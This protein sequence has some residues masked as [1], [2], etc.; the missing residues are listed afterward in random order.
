MNLYLSKE[1]RN[2]KSDNFPQNVQFINR[3][4]GFIYTVIMSILLLLLSLLL[5]LNACLFKKTTINA[6]RQICLNVL[7]FANLQSLAAEN[8]NFSVKA[9]ACRPQSRF[10]NYGRLQNPIAI[11]LKVGG[12]LKVG[13][14]VSK[15]R[16]LINPAQFLLNTQPCFDVVLYTLFDFNC[17]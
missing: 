16:R 12:F 13:L 4:H 9:A 3:I 11:T 15:F 10:C 5:L 1:L 17:Q 6:W 7:V 2:F 8:V 14:L